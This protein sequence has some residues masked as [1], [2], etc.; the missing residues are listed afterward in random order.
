M[1]KALFRTRG[2]AE[3]VQRAQDNAHGYPRAA[4]RP[5]TGMPTDFVVDHLEAIEPNADGTVF[6]LRI[7]EDCD[8]LCDGTGKGRV[9]PGCAVS[10]AE[11]KA[12][13]DAIAVQAAA[14][15]W[16]PV[17]AKPADVPVLE[18]LPVQAVAKGLRK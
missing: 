11:V 8:T 7:W 5:R 1:K 2:R 3:Q 6:A 12:T 14:E 9:M 13:T 15:E 16:D 18:E 10:L 4:V 17:S